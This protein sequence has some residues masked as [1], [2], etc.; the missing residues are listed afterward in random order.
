MVASSSAGASSGLPG[1]SSAGG[2]SGSAP[3]AHLVISEVVA[4]PTP[5]EF[6]EIYNPTGTT[7]DLSNYY[8]SDNALYHGIAAGQPFNPVLATAGTDFLARFPAGTTLAPDAVLV[9]ATGTGFETTYSRCPDFILAAT[10][11][12]CTNGT[13]AAMLSPTNGGIGNTVGLS[14]NREMLVLFS[15]D[16]TAATVKDVDYVTWG[17]SFDAET[18]ADKTAVSGYAADTAAANQTPTLVPGVSQ[19]LTRCTVEGAE[20]ATGGNGLTGHDETG[21][22]LANAFVV[23]TS[24]SPGVKNGCLP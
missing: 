5:G 7:V 4:Q 23:E 13:A 8:L 1:S 11:F 3:P 10:A 17:A 20:P 14:N 2:S 9:V 24:P 6:V 16:G 12:T 19:S 15:W 18:R 21:E 22:D